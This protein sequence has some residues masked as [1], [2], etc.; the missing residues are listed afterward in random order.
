MRDFI[1]MKDFNKEEIL[2]ILEKS[3][4]LEENPNVDLAKNKIAATLFFKPSTKTR[5]SFTSA[6]LRVGAVK[7]NVANL[8]TFVSGIKSPI[9]CDNRKMIGY[10][11]ERKIV[12]DG[13]VQLLQG[14]DFDIVCRDS[15]CWNSLGRIYS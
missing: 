14:M 10:P 1:A 3:R 11:E 2:E 15:H 4:V 7:L 5:L 6:Y 9:Y 8:F 13:F 12:V